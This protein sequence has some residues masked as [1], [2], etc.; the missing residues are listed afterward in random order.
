MLQTG[1]LV[2]QIRHSLVGARIHGILLILFVGC[3][4]GCSSAESPEPPPAE[5][6]E[7][8]VE[9]EGAEDR[10]DSASVDLPALSPEECAQ[11]YSD[12]PY[13][14]TMCEYETVPRLVRL[15]TR[16]CALYANEVIPDG[17]P[18]KNLRFELGCYDVSRKGTKVHVEASDLEFAAGDA[19]GRL[20]FEGNAPVASVDGGV[21]FGNRFLD[22][23]SMELSDADGLFTQGLNQLAM[24]DLV[25]PD[26]EIK[27]DG[28]PD[29]IA[30]TYG[31]KVDFQCG[32]KLVQNPRLES[33]IFPANEYGGFN[34]DRA[35]DI[36]W[37]DFPLHPFGISTLGTNPEGAVILAFPAERTL[38]PGADVDA[39]MKER[40]SELDLIGTLSETGEGGYRLE[41]L[42][43][44]DEDRAQLNSTNPMG[45]ARLPDDSGFLGSF[46]GMSRNCGDC[47]FSFV[48]MDGSVS[49]YSLPYKGQTYPMDYPAMGIDFGVIP[50][51]LALAEQAD[52]TLLLAHTNRVDLTYLPD[53]NG[54]YLTSL[55]RDGTQS[56]RVVPS[57]GKPIGLISIKNEE[58]AL[59]MVSASA[60]SSAALDRN[61]PFNPQLQVWYL[62]GAERSPPF[63]SQGYSAWPLD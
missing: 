49:H 52:G 43:S 8:E 31:E 16:L 60:F 6:V 53:A 12:S 9:E 25:N 20:R 57:N 39:C 47:G 29:A 44:D 22:T 2:L 26:G 50:Y 27:P 32:E 1:V 15:G 61:L 14:Q 10:I 17:T 34:F 5:D 54:L 38:I 24:A 21:W 59:F 35:I 48:A 28:R 23:A 30:V 55:Y 33:S 4:V 36:G 13:A 42:I 19:E 37:G 7:V 3:F 45:F 56:T 58:G 51:D 11:A 46:S 63:T 40:W 18:P 62:G 41:T